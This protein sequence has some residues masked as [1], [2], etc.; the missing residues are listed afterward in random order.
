[1]DDSPALD[2]KLK[3]RRSL[4][5]A[6]VGAQKT[7]DSQPTP[8]GKYDYEGLYP[9]DERYHELDQYARVWRVYNDEANEFDDDFVEVAEHSLNIIL[10]LAG[11]FGSSLT[12]LLGTII[13]RLRPDYALLTV[14][15]LVEISE[16]QRAGSW[17]MTADDIPYADLR[18][19]ISQ[20]DVWT[21][22][23]WFT[24]LILS[25]LTALLCVLA[26]QWLHQY[27]SLIKGSPRERAFIRHKR[28]QSLKTWKVRE[29][30]GF[31]P[32]L[33]HTS[34]A[35]FLVGLVLYLFDLNWNIAVCVTTL[36]APM[37]T[38]YFA[39]GIMPL[40]YPYCQYRTQL[41]DFMFEAAR[42]LLRISPK[43]VQ[44]AERA[45]VSEKTIGEGEIFHDT[46]VEALRWLNNTTDSLQAG[47]IIKKAC[48]ALLPPSKPTEKD[49]AFYRLLSEAGPKP[50]AHWKDPR[51]SLDDVE[52]FMRA[53]SILRCQ[54]AFA[55]QLGKHT[56]DA[57]VF[58]DD[59]INLAYTLAALGISSSFEIDR[60][61]KVLS[62]R[63]ALGM[64]VTN[65]PAPSA[66]VLPLHIWRKLLLVSDWEVPSSSPPPAG[67]LDALIQ[68]ARGAEVRQPPEKGLGRPISL[69]EFLHPYLAKCEWFH[70]TTPKESP[71]NTRPPVIGIQDP[72][73]TQ[74]HTTPLPEDTSLWSGIRRRLRSGGLQHPGD[75][76][77]GD[78]RHFPDVVA[79]TMSR[80]WKQ[81]DRRGSDAHG[82]QTI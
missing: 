13:D 15:L 22:G 23:L 17:N 76:E 72:T 36:C 26:K 24:S 66:P 27:N 69:V 3:P 2:A 12:S 25:M 55:S 79:L 75:I 57:V 6:R 37:I 71:S 31:L 18:T 54:P 44:Q 8:I 67:G 19:E 14:N 46:V 62:P 77:S 49:S 47:R 43:T 42:A 65:Y 7:K 28:Y 78:L 64:L 16:L 63:Q 33:L 30:I 39:A 52:S 1:M 68:D 29:I 81:L 51:L 58:V 48:G 70:Q 35:I 50:S 41:S 73:H 5:T 4:Q 32:T 80:C 53:D 59:D 56:Q 38:F 34:L 60:D 40:F 20:T 10:L 82:I 61:I 74:H 11:L 21:N 9:P 45:S